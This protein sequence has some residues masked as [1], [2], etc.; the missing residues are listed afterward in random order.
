MIEA[1][2]EMDFKQNVRSWFPH[3]QTGHI[4]L[5]HA[6]ISPISVRVKDA[7]DSFILE[8]QSGP[9]DNLEKC[10]KISEET[11]KLAA[12]Y[13]N[14]DSPSAIT[15]TGNTSDGISAVAEGLQLEAGDEILL[16]SMEFPTN[17]QPYRAL[18]SRGVKTRVLDTPQNEITASMIEKRIN[19]K[20]KVVSISAVQF[21]SGYHAD[22][23]AI[24]KLC[25]ERGVWFVVDAI[26][27]LGA[28]PIDV[29]ACRISA[30]ASGSHKWLM[31]PMGT[32]ILYTAPSL[33]EK[34]QPSKTGWLSVEEPWDLF[35]Y[36]QDW[37]PYSQHLETGT[38]NM[39]GLAGLGASL[40]MFK[41]IGYERIS[42][43]VLTLSGYLTRRLEGLSGVKVISPADDAHRAGIVS[44]TIDR[45]ENVQAL[46]DELKKKKI[47]ISSRE[48]VLRIAP[49]FYNTTAE[50]D[51]CL[52]S[53]PL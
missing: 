10:M 24:G 6:A 35:Q 26:Q 42:R 40:K 39:I 11:R 31:S 15:F 32:G 52:E 21:L 48:G 33:A 34:L 28:F 14:A 1:S 47:T 4:Y 17:V 46:T 36:E 12:D 13:L 23:E 9:I 27:C 43:N 19:P 41:E 3:T 29:Q 37:L 18:A 2:T 38:P 30:L 49:H 16:N 51:A 5:N 7:I 50:L 45:I 44:F 25:E 53:L 8:R 20:T 22:L